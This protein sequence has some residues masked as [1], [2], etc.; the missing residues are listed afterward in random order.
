M[1]NKDCRITISFPFKKLKGKFEIDLTLRNHYNT[2]MG[3]NTVFRICSN[4]KAIQ[5]A[6]RLQNSFVESCILLLQLLHEPYAN[7]F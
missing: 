6:N 7:S 4:F 5:K 3:M 1:P 2:E